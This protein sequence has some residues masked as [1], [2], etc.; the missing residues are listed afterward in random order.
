MKSVT[1]L[2]TDGTNPHFI[3]LVKKLDQ[4][5]DDLVGGNVMRSH[6]NQYNLL[7]KIHDVIIAYCDNKPVGCCSYKKYDS[8]HSE[9]KRLFVDKDYRKN[10]IAETMVRMLE[11]DSRS[12][13]YKY[14]ILETGRPLVE[15]HKLYIKLGYEVISNYGQY[16]DMPNSLCMQKT[17]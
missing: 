14:M 15:A 3:N 12:C 11:E 8:E 10:G 16:A 9:L 2:K 5:L 13:G 17:L 4:Y 7:D 1:Y 6:Y